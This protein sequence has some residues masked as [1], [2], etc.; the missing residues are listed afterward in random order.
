LQTHGENGTNRI[1]KIYNSEDSWRDDPEEIEESSGCSP[2]SSVK[3]EDT[4]MYPGIWAKHP[5]K[6]GVMICAAA[7]KETQLYSTLAID[8]EGGGKTG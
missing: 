8:L 6:P 3:L 1:G 2:G 5:P 4:R 7:T